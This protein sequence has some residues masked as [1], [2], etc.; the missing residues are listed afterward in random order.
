MRSPQI[1]FDPKASLEAPYFLD[2]LSNKGNIYYHY[3][4]YV[5]FGLIRRN[6]TL[7]ASNKDE[8]EI[9]RRSLCRIYLTDVAPHKLR[10]KPSIWFRKIFGRPPYHLALKKFEYC[11]ALNMS[12][13]PV[14]GLLQKPHVFYVE[15]IPFLPLIYNHDGKRWSRLLRHARTEVF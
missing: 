2:R 4:S 9:E 1:W 14:A 15:N 11:M 6:Y 5:R 13:L 8:H 7:E 10:A 3:T 12:G